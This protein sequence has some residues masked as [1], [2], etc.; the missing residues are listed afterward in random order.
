VEHDVEVVKVL[1]QSDAPILVLIHD[2]EH[3]VA[4]ETEAVDS[5]DAKGILVR[6]MR[7]LVAY[8]VLLEPL[9][10]LKE[11]FIGEAVVALSAPLELEPIEL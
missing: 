5:K 8:G 1:V 2:R 11:L 6:C 7:H 9:I 4:Q 10:K 3:P